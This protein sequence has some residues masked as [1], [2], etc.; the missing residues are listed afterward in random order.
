MKEQI[1]N[2][3][4]P[5]FGR[6][7][8][9]YVEREEQIRNLCEEFE[10]P[11][12]PYQTTMIYGQRGC[13]KTAFM[14]AVSDEMRKKDDWIV[15]D[16][17]SEGNI[18][19]SY[20]QNIYNQSTKD[21]KKIIDKVV[22]VSLSVAGTGIGFTLD[23]G[24]PNYTIML[25]HILTELDKHGQKV[26]ATIDEVEPNKNLKEFI[27]AYKHLMQMN[28]PIRLLMAGLPQ[29]INAFQNAKG[30]TF[31]LRAQRLELPLLNIPIIKRQYKIA[32]KNTKRAI[33]DASLTRMALETKGY[34]Y[35]FQLMGYLVWNSEEVD[36]NAAAVEDILDDY[37]TFL[38]AN[39]YTA[40]CNGLSEKDLEFI[41]AMVKNIESE[42]KVKME[43]IAKTLNKDIS[44]ISTYRKR[45]IADEIISSE[46]HG[47][48]MFILP[49]FD[50]YVREYLMY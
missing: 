47:Y 31:L 8:P 7:P 27:F 5:S 28:L 1:L 20:V 15:V 22:G 23:K 32:F 48:V 2:P 34:A 37:K 10:N 45:L 14:V 9:V 26:L 18:L 40:I 50:E 13:G 36:V 6:V 16:L 25:E 19:L 43:D 33:D 24:E 21:L 41:K 49:Y 12:S 3:F 17:P 44:Y 4:N 11:N 29:N 39:A 46:G 35:A 30:L 42:K 38:Y